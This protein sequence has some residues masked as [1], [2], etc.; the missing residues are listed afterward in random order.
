MGEINLERSYAQ[1]I[2]G[3]RRTY[4]LAGAHIGFLP[5]WEGEFIDMG[6][7]ATDK[8]RRRVGP[9]G[10][11]MGRSSVMAQ[12]SRFSEWMVLA[13]SRRAKDVFV[14]GVL[15]TRVALAMDFNPFDG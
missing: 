2:C 5:S 3:V 15:Y 11:N 13:T 7:A 4:G 8:N 14:G 10:G 12:P 9:T 1:E 6:A